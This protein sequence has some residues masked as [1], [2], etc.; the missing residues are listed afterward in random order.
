M[1]QIER[2]HLVDNIV[3]HLSQR[4]ERSIQQRAVNDYLKNVDQ[5]LG[6]RVAQGLGLETLRR[7]GTR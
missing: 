7:S 1:S 5:D 4:V 2:D 6:A 3:W